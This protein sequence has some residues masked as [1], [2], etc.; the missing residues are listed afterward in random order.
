MDVSLG[1]LYLM[2]A[3]S[4]TGSSPSTDIFTVHRHLLHILASASS[5]GTSVGISLMY[6]HLPLSPTSTSHTGISPIYLLGLLHL[7][8]SAQYR[9]YSNT[10]AT[11]GFS[12]VYLHISSHLRDLLPLVG[13]LPLPT[14]AGRLSIYPD[15]I[16]LP[17]TD[18]LSSHLHTSP[19]SGSPATGWSSIT[20]Y[21]RWTPPRIS[22]IYQRLLGLVPSTSSDLR[23]LSASF[24]RLRYLPLSTTIFRAGPPR[25]F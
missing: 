14:S 10:S 20:I 3:P 21:Q 22:A 13:H 23:R 12:I 24:C 17:S 5:V 19:A 1:L 15:T 8:A 2:T 18:L 25:L 6:R 4:S 16:P 9:I 11:S 7:L